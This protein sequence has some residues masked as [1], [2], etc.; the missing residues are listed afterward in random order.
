M[1]LGA[2]AIVIGG[3]A[4]GILLLAPVSPGAVSVPLSIGLVVALVL[5]PFPAAD[6]WFAFALVLTLPLLPPLGLPNLPVSAVVIGIA[7]IR[8]AFDRSSPLPRNALVVLAILWLPLAIGVAFS[9]WPPVSMWLR[10]TTILLLAAAASV[11]GVLSWRE[12]SRRERWLDGLSLGVLVVA[13]SAIAVFVSQSVAPI[14]SIVDGT[15]GLIGYLR[16]DAAQGKFDAANNWI[17]WGQ[18]ATLRAVSPLLPSPNNTGGYLGLLIPFMAVHGI[19]GRGPWRWVARIAFVFGLVALLATFSRSS[20]LAMAMCAGL[21]VAIAVIP[22]YR[23]RLALDWTTAG[24][25][26]LIVAI[27]LAV[28]IVMVT[29]VGQQIVDDRVTAPL[30]DESVTTRVDIDRQAIGAIAADWLHGAGLGNWEA[31]VEQRSGRAYIHNVY[32][33]YGSAVGI[34]GLLWSLLLVLIPL[35]ASIVIVRR[36]IGRHDLSLG[37]AVLAASVFTA[38][39][40]VFD[41]NLLNPQYAWMLLLVVGGSLGLAEQVTRGADAPTT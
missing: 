17:I 27:T 13:A 30:D 26:V 21:V 4:S 14:G 6:R 34:F 31:N 39:Q 18:E 28:G 22:R 35:G 3:I 25:A 33:E 8:L 2:I 38:I 37:L 29:S 16:G 19:I 36:A 5:L 9:N 40:F 41:D 1:R 23:E 15:A 20:W 7:L 32:L 10:P 11:L 12:P 24:R